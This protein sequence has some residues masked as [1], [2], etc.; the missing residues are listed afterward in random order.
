MEST[1]PDFQMGVS[2]MGRSAPKG[3]ALWRFTG[4][5]WELAKDAS[6]KGAVPSDP[7]TVPGTFVGQM[8]STP[9]V[10]SSA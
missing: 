10:A 1:V 2:S 5:C 4:Q 9:S 6:V 3:Y 8:R 7:P